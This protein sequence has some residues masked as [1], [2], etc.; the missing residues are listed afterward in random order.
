MSETYTCLVWEPDWASISLLTGRRLTEAEKLNYTEEY[1]EKMFSSVGERNELKHVPWQTLPKRQSDGCFPGTTNCAW[2][3]SEEEKGYYLGLEAG[4][5]RAEEEAALRADN[6]AK[7]QREA[8]EREKEWDL[9]GVQWE[10]VE[11]KIRDEGGETVEYI[12]TITFDGGKS[13]RFTERNVF[14]FG[15]VIN[16]PDHDGMVLTATVWSDFSPDNGWH[17]LRELGSGEQRAY[18]L[19]QKYGRFSRSPVRM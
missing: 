10:T 14:D 2:I 12:H 16:S 8:E 19:V 5:A 6:E 3:L 7:R 13:Y 11:K 1:R 15:R 4:L 17:I 9:R 18:R